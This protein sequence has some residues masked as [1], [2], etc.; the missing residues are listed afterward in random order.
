MHFYFLAYL[1]LS[2]VSITCAVPA[3]LLQSRAPTKFN[4]RWNEQ[5]G[6]P[7]VQG[8]HKDWD[9]TPLA[10]LLMKWAVRQEPVWKKIGFKTPLRYS[11]VYEVEEKKPFPYVEVLPNQKFG[12]SFQV[13]SDGSECKPRS[14]H[15]CEGSVGIEF[16][17]DYGATSPAFY[18]AEVLGVS[19][20]AAIPFDAQGLEKLEW[21]RLHE[22][23]AYQHEVYNRL[24]AI[25]QG[26]EPPKVNPNTISLRTQADV[27]WTLGTK[28]IYILTVERKEFGRTRDNTEV[29]F[30]A[31][32]LTEPSPEFVEDCNSDE[33]VISLAKDLGTKFNASTLLKHAKV[34]QGLWSNA[35]ALGVFDEG[36]WAAID[37]CYE[38]L[39]NALAIGTGN[40][41]AVYVSK[42]PTPIP[43]SQA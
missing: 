32:L 31:F 15:W 7:W 21:E 20:R 17:K 2:L 28:N 40:P 13:G 30:D 26:K 27:T 16:P 12:F 38:A 25:E 34:I 10:L 39:L 4:F 37:S 1:A 22:Q 43:S 11:T 29:L 24:V 36:L 3:P 41:R 5:L 6:A 18:V 33:H 14:M 42:T 8:D 23:I 19:V 9:P 35:C